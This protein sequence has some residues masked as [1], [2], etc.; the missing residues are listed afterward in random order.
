MNNPETIKGSVRVIGSCIYTLE[1][2]IKD[3]L[4]E[5]NGVPIETR[6]TKVKR[7]NGTVTSIYF[8]NFSSELKRMGI[9][10]KTDEL[11]SISSVGFEFDAT[12]NSRTYIEDY[13]E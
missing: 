3:K 6:A 5:V 4:I 10:D 7:H 13:M 12:S 8:R 1:V 9:I 11:L 2:N